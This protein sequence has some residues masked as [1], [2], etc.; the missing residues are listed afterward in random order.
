M[1]LSPFGLGTNPKNLR[2]ADFRVG[3]IDGTLVSPNFGC[4]TEDMR[5]GTKTL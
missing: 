5:F 4:M 3:Y 2:L 1:V